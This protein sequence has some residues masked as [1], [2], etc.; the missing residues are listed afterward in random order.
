MNACT[1]TCMHTSTFDT[2]LHTRQP[3]I[4]FYT[5]VS[6]QTTILLTQVFSKSLEYLKNNMSTVQSTHIA[7]VLVDV[8]NNADKDVDTD[9]MKFNRPWTV[10]VACCC[11]PWPVVEQCFEVV[12]SATEERLS[13]ANV[14]LHTAQVCGLILMFSFPLSLPPPLPSV[15]LSDGV[16]LVESY[17]AFLG[18][19]IVQF[20]IN[21]PDQLQ[22]RYWEGS[23]ADAALSSCR[24]L[25]STVWL[26]M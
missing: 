11:L 2:V 12:A 19:A 25:L 7:P 14:Q 8:L 17:C 3:V 20:W 16:A 4:H 10:I 22:Q 6:T 1:R 9:V 13:Q 5:H 15:C 18:V 24:A 26:Q 23:R 21:S